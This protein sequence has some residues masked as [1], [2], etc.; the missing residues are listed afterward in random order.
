MVC[1]RRIGNGAW[2][3]YWR[4]TVRTFKLACCVS[5]Q[6]SFNGIGAGSSLFI[7]PEIH[8]VGNCPWDIPAA[9]IS[10]VG[11]ASLMWGIK[12]L[13]AEM[14]LTDP[15]ALVAIMVGI[16]CIVAFVVRALK[17]NA[18]LI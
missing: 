8:V 17:T 10:L 12:R 13:A 7:L 14:S 11:M 3:Y 6:H 5:G 15:S 16:L 9:I 4:R 2:S 1:F 18:P